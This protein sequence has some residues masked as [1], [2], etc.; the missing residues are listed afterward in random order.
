[1]SVSFFEKSGSENRHL[2]LITDG[3]DS[4]SDQ[5]ERDAAVRNILGTDINVH[6]ISYTKME[7]AV[8]QQRVKSVR[9]GGTPRKELPPGADIPIR[10]Q[11][12]TYPILTVNLDREM[13]RKIRER[14]Q[15]LANSEKALAELAENTNGEIFLPETKDEMIEKTVVLAKNIDSQ[16]VVTYTPKRPL[17]DGAVDEVRSI[18]VSS[19]RPGLDVQGRRKLAVL[20]NRRN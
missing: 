10:G 5:K 19:K 18:Q 6:V 20:N 9:G 7:Q 3:L 2:I 14:G 17:A 11:T 15:N 16:Y 13:M 1:L 8:V 12:K 4:L